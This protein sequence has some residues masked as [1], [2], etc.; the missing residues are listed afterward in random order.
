MGFVRAHGET[1]DAPGEVDIDPEDDVSSL[2]STE[3]E[4]MDFNELQERLAANEAKERQMVGHMDGV[5]D[6]AAKL[7]D[8][9]AATIRR[10]E[11]ASLA[12]SRMGK[13][14]QIEELTERVRKEEST[15]E[16]L[17]SRLRGDVS[18]MRTMG[19]VW[20]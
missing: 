1:E 16:S 4:E 2:A 18:P 9:E 7:A 6:G 17:H 10:L 15:A 20:A 12:Q 8:V 3:I 13:Q 19:D 14:V 5:E 11:F